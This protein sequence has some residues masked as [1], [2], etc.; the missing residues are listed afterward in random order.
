MIA[1]IKGV[2]GAFGGVSVIEGFPDGLIFQALFGKKIRVRITGELK[3][4]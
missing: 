2:D 4:S 1:E 3:K